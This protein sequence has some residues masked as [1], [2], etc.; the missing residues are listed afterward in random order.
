MQTRRD[1]SAFP[2]VLAISSARRCCAQIE[3]V[4]MTGFVI[5]TGDGEVPDE[6]LCLS[7]PTKQ[8]EAAITMLMVGIFIKC[9]AA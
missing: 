1:A 4:G 2:F 5:V 6:T 7:Q 3:L 8:I 9:N